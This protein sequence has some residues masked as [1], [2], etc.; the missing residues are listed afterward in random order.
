MR[1][2]FRTNKLKK[3]F[4]SG[5]EAIRAYGPDVGKRYIQRIQIIQSASDMSEVI[6]LPGLNCHELV[7]NRQGQWSVSLTGFDRLIFTVVDEAGEEI[8]VE[9]VSKHYD[10]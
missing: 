10:D 3:R 6:C 7:G 1:V 2:R 4:E 9:E 5:K 8:Q